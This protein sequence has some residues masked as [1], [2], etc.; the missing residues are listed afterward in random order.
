MRRLHL[1]PLL[2]HRFVSISRDE[3]VT[4]VRN[5]LTHR[6]F[7]VTH[8]LKSY[9]NQTSAIYRFAVFNV[10]SLIKGVPREC[11]FNLKRHENINIY[12]VQAYGRIMN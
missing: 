3:D 10:Q 8:E 2:P 9:L 1:F 7:M 6:F 12:K 5:Y 4:K 11:N